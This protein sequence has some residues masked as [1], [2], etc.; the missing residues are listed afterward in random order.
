MSY[1]CGAILGAPD[2]WKIPNGYITSTGSYND[3][4][5]V[6]MIIQVLFMNVPPCLETVI[7]AN[8][9]MFFCWAAVKKLL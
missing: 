4:M 3:T 9:R 7:H 1:Y 8:Y 6:Q 2:W 5:V